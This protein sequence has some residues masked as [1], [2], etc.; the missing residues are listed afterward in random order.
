VDLATQLITVGATLS[1]VVLT[2]VGSVLLERRRAREAHRLEALR[3]GAEHTKW[4]RDE[5][6][7]AYAG[8]AAAI[9][10]VQQFMRSER[11]EA[12]RWHELRAD[13]RKAY[14]HVLLLGAEEPRVAGQRVWRLAGSA[15]NDLVRDLAGQDFVLSQELSDRVRELRTHF[16]DESNHFLAACR[17][18]LQNR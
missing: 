16:G 1:G 15:G 6:M 8:F 3:L 10:D 14:N 7:R 2:M 4:L 17:A 13:L 9:E 18:D 5:R 12:A 11:P